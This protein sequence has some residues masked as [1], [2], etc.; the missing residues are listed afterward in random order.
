MVFVGV[1]SIGIL[2]LGWIG[3]FIQGDV[4]GY[5]IY[6]CVGVRLLEGGRRRKTLLDKVATFLETLIKTMVL[7]RGFIHG[8]KLVRTDLQ[9]SR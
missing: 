6:S 3:Q 2:H 4:G 5:I 9:K 8:E 1:F 7:A